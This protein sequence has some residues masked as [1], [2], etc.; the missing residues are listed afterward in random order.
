MALTATGERIGSSFGA[1]IATPRA[2]VSDGTDVY[3]FSPT[4]GYRIDMETAAVTQVGSGFGSTENGI[5]SAMIINGQIVLFGIQHVRMYNFDKVT[6]GL[7]NRHSGSVTGIV[8]VESLRGIEYLDGVIYAVDEPTDALYT[9]DDSDGS[10]TKIAN[11]SR[12]GLTELRGNLILNSLGAYDGKLYSVDV[13][14]DTLLELNTTLGTA[15]RIA[16]TNTLLALGIQALFE[17]DGDFYALDNATDSL[18]RLYDVKWDETIADF[19]VEPGGNGTLDLTGISQDAASF[20]STGTPPSWASVSGNDLV[21]TSAPDISVDTNYDIGVRATRD[22]INADRTLR[23]VVQNVAPTPTITSPVLILKP[24]EMQTL[25]IAWSETV[26]NFAIG[27]ISASAGTL[28]NF[29]GSGADYT[30]DI[31]APTSGTGDIVISIAENVVT[32]DNN[33]GSLTIPYRPL[34]TP[35]ITFDETELGHGGTATATIEWSEAVTGFVV[36]DI[37]VDVGTLS[38]FSGSGTTY[39]VD[40]TAPS[41]G[42]ALTLTIAENAI[43]QRNA[44]ATATL[45]LEVL[46]TLTM[47]LSAEPN[48]TVTVTIA[49]SASATGLTLDDLSTDLGTLANLQGSGQNY[50]VDLQLPATGTATVTLAADAVNEGNTAASD[51]V[52][53]IQ[54]IVPVNH[55]FLAIGASFNVST[56][57]NAPDGTTIRKIRVSGL[58]QGFRAFHTLSQGGMVG[59]VNVTGTPDRGVSGIWILDVTYSDGETAQLEIAYTAIPKT[60]SITPVSRVKIYR[61]VGANLII[62]ITNY[63]G[64]ASVR[65]RLIG[66]NHADIADNQGDPL[67]IIATATPLDIITAADN[68]SLEIRMAHPMPGSPDIVA[69]Q[70]YEV[71]DETPPPMGSV[72]TSVTTGGIT[73]TWAA[74]PGATRYAYKLNTDEAWTDVGNVTTHTIND[75]ASGTSFTYEWR[76]NSPWIGDAVS[77]T[78]MTTTPATAPAKVTNVTVT[79]VSA[80]SYRVSWSAP[81]D[82]GSNITDYEIKIGSAA[83]AALSSTA[84]ATTI[85]RAIEGTTYAI[86]VRAVNSVGRG[87]ESDV[88]SY[89]HANTPGTVRSLTATPSANGQV[90]LAWLAP[91]STGGSA[92]TRYE[93]KKSTETSWTSTGTATSV[94]VS[95]T[96]GTSVTYQ[97]RA[98]NAVGA[99]THLSIVGRAYAPVRWRTPDYPRGEQTTS[100]ATYLGWIVWFTRHDLPQTTSSLGFHSENVD[101]TQGTRGGFTIQSITV[102]GT[103]TIPERGFEASSGGSIYAYFFYSGL[104][105]GSYIDVVIRAH[106]YYGTTSDITYRLTR[107]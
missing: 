102:T 8:G 81:S 6:G 88:V 82:G 13:T 12:F 15:T 45:T 46:A 21:V 69:N 76:V 67:G 70:P 47:P 44:Q 29:T 105:V 86:Q 66:L 65:G 24:G 51:S 7:T 5:F 107:V 55:Q 22:G 64:G 32:P 56:T 40:I 18:F 98:V 37:S 93:Y 10:L 62:P 43:N 90:T 16:H 100:R 30:V 9:M 41:S 95:Q 2:A 83:W 39:T 106:G 91:S 73:F 87:P 54:R 60:P 42:T 96:N 77:A 97:V 61:N 48:A 38:N 14:S 57:V 79:R 101:T 85:T 36:G 94:V 1:T 33:A 72:S 27:D 99:G 75:L 25:S 68:E 31:T 74:V 34:P 103:G 52:Q 4:S 11:I 89:T 92:I 49:F 53:I 20:A 19:E 23:V 59:T 35:T 50:T 28:S 104:T 71:A 3:V 63:G 26:T 17:H 80:T 84:T 58:L 78:A